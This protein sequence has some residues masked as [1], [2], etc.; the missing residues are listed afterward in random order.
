MILYR[1]LISEISKPF[2]A[3]LAVLVALFASFSAARSLSDAVNGLLPTDTIAA[4]IGLDT[5]IALEVLIP[6]S[7]YISVVLALGKLYSESEIAAMFALRF[8]PARLMAAVMMLSFGLALMVAALSLVVRPWAYQQS[9]E[10]SKQA[11]AALNFDDMEAGSFYEDA[12]GNRV[13]F[14]G[15][16]DGPKAPAKNVFVQLGVGRNAQIIHARQARQLRRGNTQQGAQIEL[17]GAHI[18]QLGRSGQEGDRV[19]LARHMVLNLNAPELTPPD[20][21]S[22]AASTAVLAGSHNLRDISEFQWRLSTWLTTVLLGM[23]GVPLSR[24]RP[25]QGRYAKMGTAILIYAGYY[26]L[27]NSARTW[28]QQGI[29][30]PFPGVWWV[31]ALLALLLLLALAVPGLS[32]RKGR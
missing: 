3:V 10:L 4:L 26:L 11:R 16:R 31:P 7:L 27:F 19:L 18:Y 15:H 22:L 20:Y 12:S 24:S 13:I 2:I 14:I 5:L 17:G 1:Y 23:L 32:F 9:H 28:L 21:S 30:P 6:I 8:T 29:V 25:R